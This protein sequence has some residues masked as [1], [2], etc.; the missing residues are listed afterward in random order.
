MSPPCLKGQPVQALPAAGSK[1]KATHAPRAVDVASADA[2]PRRRRDQK[3]ERAVAAVAD[4]ARRSKENSRL[5]GRVCKRPSA[6]PKS[7]VA[8]DWVGLLRGL[9]IRGHDGD[10]AV[11]RRAPGE[12]ARLRVGPPQSGRNRTTP[13]LTCNE[14]VISHL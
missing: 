3:P 4:A 13:C 7:K 10:P 8:I 11:K 14:H 5:S 6:S 9:P 2:T 1:D 12:S